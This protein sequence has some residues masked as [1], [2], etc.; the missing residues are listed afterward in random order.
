[1]LDTVNGKLGSMREIEKT[2]F[3]S[4][5]NFIVEFPRWKKEEGARPNEHHVYGD[6]VEFA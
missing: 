6:E 4:V 5:L 3:R 1:L 2:D